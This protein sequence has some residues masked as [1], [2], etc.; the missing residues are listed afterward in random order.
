MRYLKSYKLF[1]SNKSADFNYKDY[2]Y[3][4]TDNGIDI[5]FIS[6]PDNHFCIKINGES[7]DM[8]KSCIIAM[9]LNESIELRYSKV[10]DN[11]YIFDNQ[12]VNKFIYLIKDL[13]MEKLSNGDVQWLNADNK[14]VMYQDQK[15]QFVEVSY[16]KVWSFFRSYL[17]TQIEVE[18]GFMACLIEEAFK[19]RS[20]KLQ[21]I[22]RSNTA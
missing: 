10:L 13:K 15:Y 3:D 18:R 12:L 19:F 5:E 16:N 21:T 20:P 7:E 22:G 2:F 11:F 9:E 1:E 17:E 8:V 4:I 6:F 14:I